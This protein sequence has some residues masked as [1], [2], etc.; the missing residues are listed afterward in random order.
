[1]FHQGKNN[2]LLITKIT[3]LSFLAYITYLSKI[4]SL[5]QYML[6]NF[7]CKKI[8]ISLSTTGS[9]LWLLSKNAATIWKSTRD[10]YTAY[11][12]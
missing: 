5:Q 3:I 2:I 4:D 7:V 8:K 11:Y 10:V 9:S 12:Y 6:S 1:M